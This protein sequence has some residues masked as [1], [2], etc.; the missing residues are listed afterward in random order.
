MRPF[1]G[2]GSGR[3][4]LHNLGLYDAGDFFLPEERESHHF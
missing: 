3:E 1:G 4:K 2:I